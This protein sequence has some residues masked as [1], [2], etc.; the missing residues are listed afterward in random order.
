MANLSNINGKFVVEQTTGYVGVG[1]TDPNYPI[2]VLNA[3]AEIALNASGGS[4]YRVQSD[5]ASN[6]II[7]KAGVGDRLVINSA[8][9]ATF[10]GN[11]SG[12][13]GFFNSGATNVVATF[14]STDGTATLQCAD[15]TGNVEFGASG[16][17]FVVQPAGGVAQLTVGSSSSTFAGNVGIG[18]GSAIPKARLHVMGTTGLPATSGTTFTGTM[19]LGVSG[20]G[21]VMDFGAVGPSTGTQWIQVTDSSNQAFHYPLLLQPNGGNVGIGTVSPSAKLDVRNDDGLAS[22]LH[23]IA[24]FN[25]AAGADAQ[26]ILGYFANGSSVDGPCVYAANGKPLILA[27]G[28]EKLRI[29]NSAQSLRVKGGA[30]TGS[31][32]M[33]FVNSAGTSQGYFGYGGASNILYIVQ[34]VD[35]DIQFYSNGATRMTINTAGDVGIGVAPEGN[36]VSYVKQLRIGEQ[37]AIQGHADGVG[38]SSASWFSTNYIFSVGG[39]TAINTG[40]SMVY[41]AQEGRHSFQNSEST[42]AGGVVTLRD[43]FSIEPN[44]DLKASTKGPSHQGV[45]VV[46]AAP[47]PL[48]FNAF[49]GT[50]PKFL[51]VY[52]LRAGSQFLDI[53]INTTSDNIMYYAMFRGYFYGRGSRWSWTAGYTYQGSIINV[54]NHFVLNGNAAN[55]TAYRG[56]AGSAYPANLCLRMDSG[57]SGYTE[58]YGEL[59]IF[60]HA[61]SLQNGFQVAAFSENNAANPGLWT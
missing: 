34:Q 59:Y 49:N 2:E 13:R 61:N 4:I 29:Q 6:F 41:Q 36:I 60:A 27:P 54:Q 58:G 43:G 57:S 37:T 56:A 24:D 16:N 50:G 17:N 19:R 35:G 28:T 33:Q 1:T 11:I 15:P 26:M 53:A 3:S 40:Q 14:T 21:T 42:T 46:Y 10:A 32:Y 52:P 45:G 55:L 23:I 20:Y 5:S 25:R 7:R 18:T 30:V 51:G 9:N 48:R 39:S 22:G 44:L 12:V 8:G 47:Y 38:G 31:N